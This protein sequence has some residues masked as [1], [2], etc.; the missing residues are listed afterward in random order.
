MRWFARS[1]KIVPDDAWAFESTEPVVL[2]TRLDWQKEI[3]G[4]MQSLLSCDE[5]ENLDLK[6]QQKSPHFTATLSMTDVDLRQHPSC[7]IFEVLCSV[8]ASASPRAET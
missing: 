1:S 5:R 7:G 6:F 3:T 4:A 2:T 8:S